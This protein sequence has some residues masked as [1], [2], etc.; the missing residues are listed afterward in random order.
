MIALLYQYK[1][2]LMSHPEAV[3]AI[4]MASCHKKCSKLYVDNSNIKSLNETMT[5]GITDRQG[6]GI[7]NMYNMISIVSQHSYGYGLLNSSNNYKREVQI[8]QPAYKE[9]QYLYHYLMKV[10]LHPALNS[11]FHFYMNNY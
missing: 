9:Q 11:R 7:P 5:Q 8:L 4:L 10:L 1:P 2:S 3:K 6:A